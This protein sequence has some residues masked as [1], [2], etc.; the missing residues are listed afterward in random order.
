MPGW[1]WAVRERPDG[2]RRDRGAVVPFVALTLVVVILGAALSVDI[3]RLA[4]A[5]RDAREV[6]DLAALDA[7]RVLDPTRTAAAQ[8]PAVVAAARASAGRNGFADGRDGALL[9]DLG[10]FDVAATPNYTPCTDPVSTPAACNGPNAV[11]VTAHRR[12]DNLFAPGSFTIDRAA[13]ATGRSG[14]G[15]VGVASSA[16]AVDTRRSAVLDAVLSQA[17]GGTAVGLTA[18][19]WGSLASASVSLGDLAVAM[20]LGPADVSTLLSRT[21]DVGALVTGLR[22]ALA[23]TGSATA[24]TALQP[25]AGLTAGRTVRLGDLITVDALAQQPELIRFS[26]AQLLETVA[27]AG[28]AGGSITAT[29]QVSLATFG[30]VPVNVQVLQAPQFAVG[31]VGTQARTAQL[32]AWTDVALGTTNLTSGLTVA[33]VASRLP[34]VV[35][36]ASGTARITAIGCT[37]GAVPD[38]ETVSA[39]SGLATVW[40]GRPGVGGGVD[41]APVADVSVLGVPTLQLTSRTQVSAGATSAAPVTVT[42]PYSPAWRPVTGGTWSL[43]A[44]KDTDVQ[45]K[46]LGGALLPAFVTTI[47]GSVV[48]TVDAALSP[49]TADLLSALGVQAGTAAVAVPWAQCRHA[50]LLQ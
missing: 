2:G 31:P 39:S 3:G 28:V 45:V 14:V 5:G 42:P 37:G 9:V 34:L 36:A 17:L 10:T 20:G 13:T 26:A 19:S 47:V 33:D 4:V 30:S 11:R 35:D 25:L 41:A 22:S 23:T 27:D 32:R 6:A 44:V 15:S 50:R 29:A 38:S 46:V 24:A 40:V 18:A 8:E 16:L 12:S 49:V 43:V 48:T 21:Y 1:W 7:A